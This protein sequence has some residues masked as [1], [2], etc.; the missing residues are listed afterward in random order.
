MGLNSPNRTS[1]SPNSQLL[2][3][4]FSSIYSAPA[5]DRIVFRPVFGVQWEK[6]VIMETNATVR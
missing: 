1:S 3:I 2:G 6:E 4:Q 5:I